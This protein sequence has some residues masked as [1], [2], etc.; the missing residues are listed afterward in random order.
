MSKII[1]RNSSLLVLL[2]T[3]SYSFQTSAWAEGEEYA[4]IG[5]Y[6]GI[7]SPNACITFGA[8]RSVSLNFGVG[9]NLA[10]APL[11]VSSGLRGP[12]VG[13]QFTF[14]VFVDFPQG[15][16]DHGTLC[17]YN[18][19]AVIDVQ[20]DTEIDMTLTV[21][22]QIGLVDG[23]CTFTGSITLIDGLRK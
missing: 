17:R 22:S 20:S 18:T 13:T 10:S 8:D 1:S 9:T 2:I 23:A 7:N 16:P 11:Q 15:F 4:P 3:L 6:C 19:R 5:T 14:L 21:P 12:T